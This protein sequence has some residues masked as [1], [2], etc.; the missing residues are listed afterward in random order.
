M[1]VLLLQTFD[2]DQLRTLYT[3]HTRPR[4]SGA[5]KLFGRRGILRR[6]YHGP[7]DA[8][9]WVKRFKIAKPECV[10]NELYEK[11]MLWGTYIP[12]LYFGFKTRTAPLF[13]GGGLMWYSDRR[14]RNEGGGKYLRHD[15]VDGELEKWGWLKHDGKSYGTQTVVDKMNNMQLITSFVKPSFCEGEEDVQFASHIEV[16]SLRTEEEDDD[17]SSMSVILYFGVDCDGYP[18]NASNCV[19]MAGPSGGVLSVRENVPKGGVEAIME[20]GVTGPIQIGVFSYSGANVS[21]EG[22]ASTTFEAVHST[23]LGKLRTH[24][25]K[26]KTDTIDVDKCIRNELEGDG[27]F[28]NSSEEQS[29]LLAVHISAQ[30]SFNVSFIVRHIDS[31]SPSSSLWPTVSDVN[32]WLQT[33]EKHFDMKFAEIYSNPSLASKE[34]RLAGQAALSNCLGSLGY[35]HGKSLLTDNVAS[36]DAELFTCVPSR[37]FFPRG[38]LWD[39]GFHQLVISTWDSSISLDV[40]WY[41]L[42]LLHVGPRSYPGAWIPREQILGSASEKRVPTEFRH[43]DPD[44]TNPPTL[45]LLV[46]KLL[47]D[48]KV[49]ESDM[50]LLAPALD[51]WVRWLLA[52]LRGKDSQGFRWRGRDRNDKRVNPITLDSGLDDFPRAQYPSDEEKHLDA[53]C[54]MILSCQIMSKIQHFLP[55]NAPDYS[56]LGQDL[57]KEMKTVHWDGKAFWDF[58][59]EAESYQVEAVSYLCSNRNREITKVEAPASILDTPNQAQPVCPKSHPHFQNMVLDKNH[60]PMRYPKQL[61]REG[62]P[63]YVRHVGYVSIF[64]LILQLLDPQEDAD[65]LKAILEM[66]HSK[67][68]LWSKHGLR[69]LST[70]DPFYHKKNGLNDEPYWRGA[71]WININFLAL[72][73]LRFYS[74][75]EG[76]SSHSAGVLY[77]RLRENLLKTVLGGFQ[78]TGFFFEQYDDV[79]GFGH[80]SHQFTGWTA[81][82]L[83]IVSEVYG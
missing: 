64:P 78:R 4:P 17:G 69:S 5:R 49:S 44:I 66:I 24:M 38:F 18:K 37:G 7:S 76:P 80:R 62:K 12:N 45:L 22:M 54:W 74:N 21:F 13:V 81:C 79:T 51:L 3:W 72:K 33:G 15:A 58:G 40:L 68:H 77:T 63:Q 28:S 60:E 48:E 65:E 57:L 41:W 25:A 10:G 14:I 31:E 1:S 36:F 32:E 83:N 46:Q 70:A 30:K 8:S 20:T 27:P 56:T 47:D 9:Q 23:A 35:F 39:E 55:S 26:T 42:S 73:A 52:T 71:V 34:Y 82:I 67:K 53:L 6:P 50:K 43:Q 19:N 11:E 16:T 2:V 61:T 75:S 29:N 59:V